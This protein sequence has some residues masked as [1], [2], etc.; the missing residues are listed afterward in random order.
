[1]ARNYYREGRGTPS[2]PERLN[3]QSFEDLRNYCLINK[4][5]FVDEFFPPCMESIGFNI[6]SNEDMKRVVWLRPKK[7]VDDPQLFVDGISRFDFSQG[8]LGNCWFLASLGSLTFQPHILKQILPLDQGFQNECYAGI[9]HFRFWRFGKWVDVVIDDKLPTLLNKSGQGLEGLPF[10]RPKTYNEFWPCLLE[11]AY[12]KVCGSYADMNAG[13]LS[14]ALM[15]FTGGLHY[16]FNLKQ[17]LPDLLWETIARA[18]KLQSLMGCGTPPLLNKKA[19]DNSV[20]PNGLVEG[21]A[22]TVT[23]VAEVLSNDKP[24]KLVRLW[25]PWGKVEW[26]GHWS[27]ISRKWATVKEEDKEKLLHRGDDGEFWMCLEDFVECFTEVDICNFTPDF[28]DSSEV[29]STWVSSFHE[30]KWLPGFTAG[31]PLKSKDFWTNPQYRVTLT[32]TLSQENQNNDVSC[33]TV[34]SLMQKPDQRFRRLSRNLYIGL[35]IFRVQSSVQ[36]LTEKFPAAFFD[37]NAPVGQS[38]GYINSREVTECFQLQPGEYLIVPSTAKADEGASFILSIFSKS[39]T[40]MEAR[41]ARDDLDI[42][43]SPNEEPNRNERVFRKF[44]DQYKEVDAEHLQTLLND[45]ILKG[46]TFQT[47]GF[48]LDDCKGI[49]ALMDQ[50]FTGRLNPGE[51][52]RLWERVVALQAM[53]YKQ[54]VT[55]IGY[56]SMIELHDAVQ[57]NGIKINDDLLNL[58]VLRYGD[59][60]GRIGLESYVV[61]ML[62]LERMAKIFQKQSDGKG[63]YLQADEWMLLT[64]YS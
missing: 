13:H 30:G 37:T 52:V 53:F 57:A 2:N 3:K 55:R 12:A 59:S 20:L 14:E 9:F 47:G 42:P 6:L 35:T 39:K 58:M 7:L 21:H 11:K 31:G 28:L 36:K 8:G 27:D 19:S 60:S 32:D 24:V 43:M 29:P 50:S 18:A 56:L 54:D 15:D 16:N 41:S 64:M 51:F 10:V 48:S 62:R 23:G 17:A 63:L 44:S 1:M 61:L 49:I 4:A 40:H 38:K 33:N 26:I 46:R 34:V 5:R 45:K 25:N 22:Y